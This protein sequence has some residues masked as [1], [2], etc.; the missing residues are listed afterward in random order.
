M[1]TR[2]THTDLSDEEAK[3]KQD[4]GRIHVLWWQR[5]GV[6]IRYHLLLGLR[7]TLVC[8]DYPVKLLKGS[9][10]ESQPVV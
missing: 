4:K 3:R 2:G 7:M 6:N 1:K 10:K 9:R 5:I 8:Y